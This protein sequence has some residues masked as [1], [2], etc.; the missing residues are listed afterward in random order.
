MGRDDQDEMKVGTVNNGFDADEKRKW[1]FINEFMFVIEKE[2]VELNE[3]DLKSFV[4]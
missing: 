3:S 4:I 2:Q 1:L